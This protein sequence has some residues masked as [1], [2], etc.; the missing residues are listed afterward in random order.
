MTAA[1]TVLNAVEDVTRVEASEKVLGECLAILWRRHAGS[2]GGVLQADDAVMDFLARAVFEKPLSDLETPNKRL[3]NVIAMLY[4]EHGLTSASYS[5]RI[6]VSEEGSVYSALINAV[7]T[8]RSCMPMFAWQNFDA[9]FRSS[10]NERRSIIGKFVDERR[11]PKPFRDFVHPCKDPR[12]D[13]LMV[14]CYWFGVTRSTGA[15]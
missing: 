5:A 14:T 3:L 2:P 15:L 6:C 12:T 7:A 4:M 9:L 1:L 13:I 8:H 10:E 11:L